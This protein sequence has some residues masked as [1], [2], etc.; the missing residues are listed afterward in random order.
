MEK[1]LVYLVTEG[2]YSDYRVLGIY[3]T[4]ELAEEAKDLFQAD[5]IDEMALDDMRGR[6]PGRLPYLVQMY[7]DGDCRVSRAAGYEFLERWAPV[8]MGNW[9]EMKIWATDEKHAA[10]IANERRAALIASGEWTTDWPTWLK[11]GKK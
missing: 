6:P 3:S 10:K 7:K 1:P 11:R 2:C 8:Y 5:D 4:R 9:V